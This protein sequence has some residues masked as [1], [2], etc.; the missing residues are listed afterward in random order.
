MSRINIIEG[1]KRKVVL[2]S[3]LYS[4]IKIISFPNNFE[5]LG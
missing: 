1:G 3:F 5:I 4:K 2:F